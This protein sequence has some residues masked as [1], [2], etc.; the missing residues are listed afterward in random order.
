MLII[1]KIK[2]KIFLGVTVCLFIAATMFNAMTSKAVEK[3]VSQCPNNGAGCYTNG[4]W[5]AYLLE[6]NT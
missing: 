5:Y 2:K 3:K 1:T 6:A 4:L